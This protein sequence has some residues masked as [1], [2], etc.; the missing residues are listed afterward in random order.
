MINLNCYG[1]RYLLN[2]LQA[3]VSILH[4]T[5]NASSVKVFSNIKLVE[6]QQCDIEQCIKLQSCFLSYAGKSSTRVV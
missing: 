5:S 1:V 2:D 3:V 6:P 4:P